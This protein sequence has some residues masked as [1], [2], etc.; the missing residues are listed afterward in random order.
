MLPLILISFKSEGIYEELHSLYRVDFKEELIIHLQ[1][2]IIHII[3][4]Y[5]F[6]I[7]LMHTNTD[8]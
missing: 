3:V 8:Q 7:L 2:R 4:I 5:I 1:H 6:C